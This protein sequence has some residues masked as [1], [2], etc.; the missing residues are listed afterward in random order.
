MYKQ[1]HKNSNI[2]KS[3]T[4]NYAHIRYIATRPRVM[5][6]EDMKHGLFGKLDIGQIEEFLDWKKV[7]QL[8]Y[9]NTQ[10]GITMYRGI[11]SISSETAL[12]INLKDQKNWQQYIERHIGTLAEKNNIKREDFAWIGAVHNEKGHPHI[13]ICFWE[14]SKTKVKNP[15]VPSKIPND[16]R[17]QLIKDT[18]KEKILSFAQQKD[19]T[20]KSLRAV[21]SEMVDEFEK[22]LRKMGNKRYQTLRHSCDE[23]KELIDS[24]NLSDEMLNNIADQVFRIKSKLPLKGRISYQFLPPEVKLQVDELVAYIVENNKEVQKLTQDY[25]TSKML[26]VALYGGTD[27]YISK[28]K[29]KYQKEAE[30][31]IANRILGMVKTL[32]RL[33]YEGKSLQ[34][35]QDRKDYY[36]TQMMYE[37]MDMLGSAVNSHNFKGTNS[38]NKLGELSK[39]TKKELYLKYQ[40]KGYEH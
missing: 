33:D 29:D 27:D 10:D 39:A 21:T 8:A 35:H 12:E 40:D 31:I 16:I 28:Q 5:K 26:M 30:K 6:N 18:F 7:A 22:Q 14:K 38:S 15:F 34:Y 36:S 2:K 17:K 37:I 19:E 3:A 23:E 1:R 20:V 11:L 25:V 9:K 32:N 4:L 24:F 13:H